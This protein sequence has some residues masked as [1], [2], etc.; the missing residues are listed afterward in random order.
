TKTLMSDHPKG[1]AVT[2]DAETDEIMRDLERR[3]RK[4]EDRRRREVATET[5]VRKLNVDWSRFQSEVAQLDD[6][7]GDLRRCRNIL[8]RMGLPNSEIAIVLSYLPLQGGGCDCEVVF[9][10]NMIKPR[11]LVSF[12]CVDCGGDFDEYDY[13]VKDSVWAASGLAPHGGLLCVGC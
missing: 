8:E 4:N 11:P 2:D 1:R 13:S 12:D 6:C 9:N 10:V 7:D 5:T 3:K